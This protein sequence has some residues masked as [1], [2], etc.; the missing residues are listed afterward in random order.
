MRHKKKLLL[1][2]SKE[3]A[4]CIWPW[5]GN[6]SFDTQVENCKKSTICISTYEEYLKDKQSQKSAVVT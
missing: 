3:Q 2:H 5:L 1:C 6:T 4:N